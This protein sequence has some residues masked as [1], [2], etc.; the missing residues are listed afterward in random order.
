MID[1]L[2]PHLLLDES[3]P[4]GKAMIVC[5]TRRIC[6]DVHDMLRERT[7]NGTANATTRG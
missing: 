5:A 4:E 2:E 3:F 7:P 6:I 1:H